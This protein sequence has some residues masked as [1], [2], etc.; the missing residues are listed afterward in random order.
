MPPK[1]LKWWAKYKP[2]E[3]S[4]D[5][6]SGPHDTDEILELVLNDDIPMETAYFR[7]EKYVDW[8]QMKDL[9]DFPEKLLEVMK[10]NHKEN[11]SLRT[12]FLKHDEDGGATLDREELTNVLEELQFPENYGLYTRN[13]NHLYVSS[14]SAT[15]GPKIRIGSNNEIIRIE[16]KN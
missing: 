4:L 9:D 16:L 5:Q 12:L 6:V 14:G 3:Y 8:L 2:N 1:K 7:E 15:W 11:T 13:N 10:E